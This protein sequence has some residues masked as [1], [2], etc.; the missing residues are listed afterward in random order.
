M[1]GRWR[2]KLASQRTPLAVLCQLL[3][4][5]PV[6]CIWEKKTSKIIQCLMHWEDTIDLS[7]F[8]LEN[9]RI[10]IMRNIKCKIRHGLQSRK[11]TFCRIGQSSNQR[12]PQIKGDETYKNTKHGL[13]LDS[14]LSWGDDAKNHIIEVSG[15]IW[16][17]STHYVN[18]K[19][20]QWPWS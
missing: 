14:E 1:K 3:F 19:L 8:L 4:V 16:T 9:H 7:D 17:M 6:G 2:Y 11:P 5:C 10:L 13:E 12:I 20:I 15:E 18:V